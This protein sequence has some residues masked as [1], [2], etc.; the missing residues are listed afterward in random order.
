M[1]IKK[2]QLYIGLFCRFICF[3][4]E[5]KVNIVYNKFRGRVIYMRNQRAI[6][7]KEQN[8]KK[9]VISVVVLVVIFVIG[10]L[11]VNTR[12]F[13]GEYNK[14][15]V[16]ITEEIKLNVLKEDLNS[17]DFEIQTA[18]KKIKGTAK[19][20]G[21]TKAK[22]NKNNTEINF[23]KNLNNIT[24]N[25]KGD[26]SKIGIYSSINLNGTYVKGKPVYKEQNRFTKIFYTEK[27]QKDV[28][29]LFTEN[30]KDLENIIFG[31]SIEDMDYEMNAKVYEVSKTGSNKNAIILTDDK[32]NFYI[33]YFDGEKF[34]YITNREEYKEAIPTR[35]KTYASV[36]GYSI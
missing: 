20:H 7:R 12:I 29:E 33:G 6:R 24:I 32:E 5:Y 35:I 9:I 2:D 1:I 18:K 31:A 8:K 19:K 17:I 15:N 16:M 28:K 23:K 11:F 27:M 14:N 26:Y 34:N 30:F 13:K 36:K 3:L 10:M 21:I 4:V 25:F 22:Y